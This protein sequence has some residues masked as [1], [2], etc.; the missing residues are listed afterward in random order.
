[1]NKT[2][3]FSPVGG[4][5]PISESN[6]QEGSLLHIC[7][8]YR[9]DTICMYLSGEMVK[10]HHEDDRYRYCINRLYE[11][12]GKTADIRVI[13][14]PELVNVHDFDYFY[15]E[16][17]KHIK[18]I[19][20]AMD[21]SDTLIINISSGTPAMKSGLL[22]LYTLGGFEA[23]L[24][25]VTTPVRGM[26]EH[27]HS[28]TLNVQDLWECNIDN[29][30]DAPNRCREVKCPTLEVL[31]KE[32]IIE[33]HLRA[34]DYPAALT[35]ALSLKDAAAGY[36]KYIEAAILRN[37]LKY[38]DARNKFPKEE[39]KSIFPVQDSN[40]IQFFEYI[41]NLIIKYRRKEFADFVRATSP[42][43]MELFM[44]ILNKLAHIDIKNDYARIDKNKGLKWD[45]NKLYHTEVLS[46]LNSSF[47]YFDPK[48][49]I[50]SIDL[51]NIIKDK[52][53]DPQAVKLA[54]DIRSVEEQIRNIAAHQ[55]VAMD[56]NYIYS[57]TG[58][59]TSE[60]V[61][62]LKHLF[63]FACR[64]VDKDSW[65]SYDR[66]NDFIISQIKK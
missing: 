16:F 10:K 45:E 56:D 61:N 9:P 11:N 13:E 39:V 34:Y 22:V 48:S 29:T 52:I 63:Q 27:H 46:I 32:K 30:P 31:T 4:T 33:Q 43:I 38:N 25:Q 24:I 1:M 28:K 49:Y 35:V 47:T 42:V 23:K 15:E 66:M 36:Q 55:V 44:L 50:K 17:L 57:E 41:Q 5:D 54:E 60:I 14:N 64:N 3:L 6:M 26:N 18:Q 12:F 65:N 7:R 51:L 59:R 62:K 20:A 2:I 58:V 53:S 19:L 40:Y 8:F 37:T 21:E